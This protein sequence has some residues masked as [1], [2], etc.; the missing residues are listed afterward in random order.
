[1]TEP[2]VVTNESIVEQLVEQYTEINNLTDNVKGLLDEAKQAGLD[3]KNLA[4]IAK[5]KS[6]GNL[7]DLHDKT[8]TLLQVMEPFV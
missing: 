2:K 3:Y 4:K 1:M 5:A 6:A 7:G 8:E